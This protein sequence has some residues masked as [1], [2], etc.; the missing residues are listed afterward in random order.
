MRCNGGGG[1]T[2]CPSRWWIFEQA[3]LLNQ[4]ALCESEK[5]GECHRSYCAVAGRVSVSG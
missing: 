1:C 2:I 3:E 4:F 5:S